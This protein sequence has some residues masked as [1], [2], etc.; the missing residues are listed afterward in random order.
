MRLNFWEEKKL[1]YNN[2]GVKIIYFVH[3]TTKDNLTGKSTG[4][5]HG[6]L[7][8]LGIQQAKDL[9]NQIEDNSFEVMFSSD[10]KRAVDSADLGFKNN[11]QIIQDER[12]RECNYGDLNQADE[13]LVNYIEHIDIPFSNGESLIS[14][15]YTELVAIR[16]S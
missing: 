10:L 9:S 3:G 14:P 16:E 15:G 1:N 8:E 13:N 4:W 6:E 2:M 12:L 7:S 11:H 5:E